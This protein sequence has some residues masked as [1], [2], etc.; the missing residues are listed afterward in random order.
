LWD[1]LLTSIC[2]SHIWSSTINQ[3]V[4]D[5]SSNKKLIRQFIHLP[6]ENSETPEEIKSN[7]KFSPYF[8]DCVGAVNGCHIPVFVPDQKQYIKRKG[9]LSQNFLAVCNFN[10]E[11]TYVMPGWEGSAHNGWLWDVARLNSLKIPKGK[12]LLGDTGFPLSDTCL[13]PYR[14]TKYHLKDWDVTGGTK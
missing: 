14:E 10:M 5:I 12:W 13:I 6:N 8:D 1:E 2:W 3:L 7:P 4:K 9:Y 11:F